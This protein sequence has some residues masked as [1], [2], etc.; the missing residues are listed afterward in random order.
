MSDSGSTDLARV[1]FVDLSGQIELLR[2]EIDQAIG[3]VVARSSFVLGP[4]VE[5][6]EREFGMYLGAEHAI[7]V[8]SGTDA[9]ELALRALGIGVNDEVITVAN[10]F[11]ATAFAISAT[12]ATPVLVDVDPD[13]LLIDSRA[14]EAAITPRTRAIVPVHLYGRCADMRAIVGIARRRK[15]A[16]VED[17]CQAHGARHDGRSAGTLGDLGCFSFYPSK[18]LGA[19]GDGGAV[20]TSDRRLAEQV[21]LLRNYGSTRRYHHQR[22][23]FNRRLDEVQAAVLRVKLGHLDKWNQARRSLAERYHAR[24][25]GVEGVTPPKRPFDDQSVHLF[26]IRCRER[27][28]LRA[29]LDERGIATQVH[30]PVPVHRQAAY[31]ELRETSLPVTEQTAGEIL[32]LPMYPELSIAA[33][34]YVCDQIAGYR[35]VPSGDGESA[36]VTAT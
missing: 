9:L 27:D 13:T 18:N 16:V 22:L 11:I 20:V 24:L 2:E 32:S 4:E 10:T 36:S 1:P 5:S 30:Y 25:G 6:F 15:I 21:R 23:G 33:L 17:A 14:V 8:S 28:R 35:A 29:V 34:D 3:R 26:V 19:L 7:G 12:G 31:R